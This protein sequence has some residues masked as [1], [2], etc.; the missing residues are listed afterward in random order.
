MVRM[1]IGIAINKV[2]KRTGN[3]TISKSIIKSFNELEAFSKRLNPAV[4]QYNPEP[5]YAKI[6]RPMKKGRR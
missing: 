3:T 2:A 5:A 4:G 6:A 1:N